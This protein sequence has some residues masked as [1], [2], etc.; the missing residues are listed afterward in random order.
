M[1]IV[2]ALVVSDHWIRELLRLAAFGLQLF[3][4]LCATERSFGSQSSFSQFIPSKLR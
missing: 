3:Y 4:A 2:V 1:M